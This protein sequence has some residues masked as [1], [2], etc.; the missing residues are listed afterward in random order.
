[1]RVFAGILLACGVEAFES[2]A[3]FGDLKRATRPLLQR[4]A[5]AALDA[6]PAFTA[7]A[8]NRRSTRHMTS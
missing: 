2:Q 1:M 3:K 8:A 4:G 5:A 6:V 7:P